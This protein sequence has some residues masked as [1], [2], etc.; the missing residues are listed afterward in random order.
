MHNKNLLFLAA[1]A[2]I[3]LFGIACVALGTINQYLTTTFS[4]DKIFI[5]LLASLFAGG[6]LAGSVSFGPIVDRFGYKVLM[7]VSLTLLLVAFQTIA[8]TS[9]LAVIQIMIFLLG[10]AGGIINGATSALVADLFVEKKGAFLSFLGV[11]WGVGAL[12]LPLATSLMLK[13]NMDYPAILSVI[14]FLVI[15]PL[16]LFVVLKCPEAKNSGGIPYRKYAQ[17]LKNPTILLIGFFLFFQSGFETLST[18]WTPRYFMEIYLADTQSALISLTV[19]SVSLTVA[20]LFLGMAMRKVEAWKVLIAGMLI[21][22]SGL[23]LM[24]F[25]GSY[26]LGLVGIAM[27]GFGAS[28]SFPVMLGYVGTMY[29]DISGAAFSLVLMMALTGNMLLNALGGVVFE[30][31]QVSSFTLYMISIILLMLALLYLIIRRLKQQHI[32]NN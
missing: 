6:A 20:R 32:L 4:V 29:P 24:K 25:G 7:I 5:G 22:L 2:A 11:F 27:L 23:I 21:T 28:A 9:E 17:M 8:R 18:T 26:S 12:S 30:T 16:V 13:I 31:W 1:C 3:M 14:G 19:M 10:L 15:V